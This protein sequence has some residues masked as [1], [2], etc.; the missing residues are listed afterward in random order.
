MENE[1]N[2]ITIPKIYSENYLEHATGPITIRMTND[3]LFRALL[4]SNN[5]VL[6]GLI[7]ALIHIPIDQILSVEI[8]NP[9]ELGKSIDEKDFFLDILM[10]LNNNSLINLEMQVI[11]EHDW[12]ERSLSYLCRTFDHLTKGESYTSVKPVIHIGILNFSLFPEYPEFYATYKFMN[13]KNHLIYSD[14]LSLS[15]LDLTHIELANDEDKH[16]EI[17]RWATL[18]KATTWEEIKMLASNNEYIQEASNTVY[19]LSQE[20]SIYWQCL[21]R[22]DYYRRQA[23]HAVTEENLAAAQDQLTTTKE[24]LADA[25]GQ[26]EDTKGQL[27][28]TR[29]QLEDTRGQLEDTKGQLEDTRGQLEDTKEQLADTKQ[30]LAQTNAENSLLQAEIARLKAQLEQNT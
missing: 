3:Y 21:A 16:F 24:Q 28:D 15:V 4:Q 30:Q 9:I 8:R 25:R 14:K 13:V 7:S 5:K 2:T 12:P 11:N 27:E 1:K 26:L 19:Q 22:E 23:R 6:K 17:D 10:E 20:E 29:G 18:F